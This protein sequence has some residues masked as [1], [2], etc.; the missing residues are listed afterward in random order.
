[1]KAAGY[2]EELYRTQIKCTLCPHYC[3]LGDGKTGICRVRK[4][5]E[6]E[7]FL[8]TYG[9]VSS[10]GF[11]PIEKKPLYHFYP[12]SIIFSVGSYGCNLHCKFCQNYEISQS[13]GNSFDFR[14]LYEPRQIVD[15]AA[16]QKGNIGI[17]FTYNEPIV[18][19]EYMR[20]IAELSRR[21]KM[22]NVIV[23]N[24]YINPEPLEEIIGW[25]DAFNVDLKAFSEDFY[26]SQTMSKLAPVLETLKHIRRRGR[27]LEITNLIITN[28]NDNKTEFTEMVK[29]IKSELGA[30]TVLHLSRY[31]P[32]HKMSE[33]PTPPGTISQLFDIAKEYLNHVYIGNL[34]TPEGQNTYCPECGHRAICRSRYDARL[35]GIDH[36][37]RCS[38]CG[39]QVLVDL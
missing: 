2:Y 37:G 33:P 6:G 17:A 16:E 25:M 5:V 34:Q 11:D 31:F 29:W 24:G 13:G 14:K 38:K 19:F 4:N 26:M 36:K 23:T 32:V 15:M 28:K 1:M 10:M 21:E 7:M 30:D 27:H 35:E 12:G 22:K 39:H 20:D 18:W 3:T 9:A 8:N